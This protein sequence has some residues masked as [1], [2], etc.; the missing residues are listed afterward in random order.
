MLSRQTLWVVISCTLLGMGLVWTPIAQAG[1]F[2]YQLPDQG[3]ARQRWNTVI[4]FTQ[5]HRV[6]AGETLLDVAR[7]YGLGFNEIQLLYP[8]TDPWIP[9]VGRNLA[10][11]TEW[12]L[13]RTQ[14]HGIVINIP[15]MR[16][17]RFFPKSKVVK[18]YPL[19]IGEEHTRTPEGSYW[20]VDRRENPFWTIP[21]SLR[22]KYEVRMIPPGP[23]NPLGKYWLGIS[24]KGYGIHGTNFAWCVGRSISNGCIRLY[25]EHIEQLFHETPV[26][27]WVEII[28]EPVKVGFR[29]GQIFVEVHPDIY[30]EIRQM[31]PYAIQRLEEYVDFSCISIDVLRTAL[32]ECNGVPVAVGSLKSLEANENPLVWKDGQAW[33]KCKSTNSHDPH[34]R[35]GKG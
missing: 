13:P 9:E 14:H 29:Q 8:H 18:T 35:E 19:G 32:K 4:G 24:K 16:L 21:A 15:E 1:A 33:S 27:T 26:G 12:V 7:L 22:H 11:H 6:G 34:E 17:Y 25:P 5:S 10:I 20:I 2:P 31:E 30:G 3:Q 23:E 28:Y